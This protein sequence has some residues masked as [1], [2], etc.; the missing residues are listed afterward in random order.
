[1]R[2]TDAFKQSVGVSTRATQ[3]HS[4]KAR[5][6]SSLKMGEHFEERSLESLEVTEKIHDLLEKLV[7]NPSGRDP[8][9]DHALAKGVFECAASCH[10]NFM[11]L[12]KPV[13]NEAELCY[14]IADPIINLLCD[15]CNLTVR[16]SFVVI[17]QVYLLFVL[18]CSRRVHS[19]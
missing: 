13:R 1:M 9:K 6:A 17:C 7:K 11:R 3:L 4:N 2:P 12:H 8:R 16:L 14:S 5:A 18:G 15:Y 19:R 10:A